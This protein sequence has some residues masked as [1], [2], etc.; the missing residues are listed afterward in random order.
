MRISLSHVLVLTILV[1]ASICVAALSSQF[2]GFIEMQ[3][4]IEGCRVVIDGRS[5]AP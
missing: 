5:A 4:S 2:G 3:C 1:P